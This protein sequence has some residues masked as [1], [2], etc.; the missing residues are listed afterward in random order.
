MYWWNLFGGEQEE[1]LV[2]ELWNGIYGSVDLDTIKAVG[3]DCSQ[4]T[5]RT[6]LNE[7]AVSVVTARCRRVYLAACHACA[8]ETSL[9]E[10]DFEFDS[11]GKPHTI[12]NN[13][14]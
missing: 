5:N 6:A 10:T 13:L 14:I 4:F 3:Q 11:F 1:W 2:E 9:N 7:N 12:N 8:R